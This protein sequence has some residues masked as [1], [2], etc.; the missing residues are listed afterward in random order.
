MSPEALHPGA[1]VAPVR[2]HRDVSRLEV[3]AGDACSLQR[4]HH[5]RH[6]LRVRGL[7]RPG[8]GA[9]ALDAERER[10][11]VRNAH[12]RP[13]AGHGDPPAGRS[14]RAVGCSR[15]SHSPERDHAGEQR[16]ERGDWHEPLH[17]VLPVR[18]QRRYGAGRARRH[19][20]KPLR[21]RLRGLCQD[22]RGVPVRPSEM[23]GRPNW[24][25]E[26][27][28]SPWRRRAGRSR[29]D[30]APSRSEFSPSRGG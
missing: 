3:A 27:R 28:Q 1:V 7:R 16:G 20:I 12:R 13:G 19:K 23:T 4:R 8:S 26:A 21:H 6:A 2:H 5:A 29:S 24:P 15:S 30:R 17:V 11:L 10:R 25:G 14:W 9:C 22:V 18:L